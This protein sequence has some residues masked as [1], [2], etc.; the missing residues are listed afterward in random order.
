[1]RHSQFSQGIALNH[2]VRL[3]PLPS[4]SFLRKKAGISASVW[5]IE[6]RVSAISV[7]AAQ[8]LGQGLA[9]HTAGTV[10]NQCQALRDDGGFALFRLVRGLHTNKNFK[11]AA[12]GRD[13][14]LARGQNNSGMGHGASSSQVAEVMACSVGAGHR[15]ESSLGSVES[16]A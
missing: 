9:A 3:R 13:K 11:H 16:V 10:H 5:S 1:M 14:G 4:S 2:V 6:N 7:N 15:E 12:L 8:G